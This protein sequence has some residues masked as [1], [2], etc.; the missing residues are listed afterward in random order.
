M[1]PDKT[2]SPPES[3]PGPLP[4]AAVW[5]LYRAAQQE[6]LSLQMRNDAL[7]VALA[8]ISRG[9]EHPAFTAAKAISSDDDMIA[10]YRIAKGLHK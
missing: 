3:P 1:M 8:A 4:V 7:R 5:A 6:K 9:T 2:E 10:A